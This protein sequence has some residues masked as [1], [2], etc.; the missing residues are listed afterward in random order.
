MGVAE[1]ISRRALQKAVYWE[2]QSSDGYGGSVYAE[3][4]E[5]SVIWQDKSQL[6]MDDQ[7]KEIIS[8]ASVWF[9][10]DIKEESMLW[11]GEL[12]D[13]DSDEIA[14]PMLVGAKQI[15]K[16]SKIPDIRGTE[17]IRKAYL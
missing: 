17:Y 11:L 3:A 1:I 13:L 2:F 5:V 6:I 15:K 12:V 8:N 14:D 7:G 16:I 9:S 4:E 10:N